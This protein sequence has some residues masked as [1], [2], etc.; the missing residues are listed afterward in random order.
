MKCRISS[1]GTPTAQPLVAR[2]ARRIRKSE[3]GLTTMMPGAIVSTCL[4][5]EH[6][7]RPSW[8]ALTTAPPATCTETNALRDKRRDRRNIHLLG[9]DVP[10]PRHATRHVHRLVQ[11]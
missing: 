8:K 11:G 5:P 6:S 1:S 7:S 4:A 10:H 2:G 3:K 9:L